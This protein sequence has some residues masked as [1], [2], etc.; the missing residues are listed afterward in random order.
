MLVGWDCGTLTVP[1]PCL[2]HTLQ[3]HESSLD[4]AKQS[5]DE[6]CFG[7]DPKGVFVSAPGALGRPAVEPP[8]EPIEPIL[9]CIWFLVSYSH[10]VAVQCP[11]CV[12][13]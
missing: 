4:C 2:I 10:G 5:S 12:R 6:Y 1:T 9:L 11:P 8:F 13:F 3:M 7:I